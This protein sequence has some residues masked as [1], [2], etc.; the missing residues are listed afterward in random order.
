MAFVISNHEWVEVF[1]IENG[2]FLASHFKFSRG[3]KCLAWVCKGPVLVRKWPHQDI[4]HLDYST[5]PSNSV[6]TCHAQVPHE[7]KRPKTYT[8]VEGR[9]PAPPG[10]YKTLSI[11][12]YLLHRL[13]QVFFHQQ[14]E[15]ILD[16]LAK[17]R[18]GSLRNLSKETSH[19]YCWWLKSCTSW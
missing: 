15:S 11:L 17:E 7:C 14:Y 4:G 1:P 16:L 13:V 12:G 9:N 6:E 8:T 5:K 10:M 19:W 18:S 3:V 2:E